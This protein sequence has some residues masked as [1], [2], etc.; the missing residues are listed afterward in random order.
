[1]GSIIPESIVEINEIENGTK[2][3]RNFAFPHLHLDLTTEDG[4]V[5]L[6]LPMN[7]WFLSI[8]FYAGPGSGAEI[9]DHISA[10]VDP[11][12]HV[13]SMLQYLG[14][15][16]GHGLTFDTI[17]E[18]DE[19]VSISPAVAANQELMDSFFRIGSFLYLG[20]TTGT[21]YTITAQDTENAKVKIATINHATRVYTHGAL[22]AHS[23]GTTIYRT[24]VA[25]DK[26]NV[27]PTYDGNVYGASKIG[28][29]KLPAGMA[30]RVH[31]YKGSGS[32]GT[33][34]ISINIEGMVG[35][36]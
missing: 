8:E 12:R 17:L 33:R 31:Y 7:F 21:E 34:D 18:G 5:D 4:Y 28:S 27:I 19:W 24:A 2:F 9:G 36:A 11:Y 20:E 29:S 13:D 3:Y 14:L 6:V 10:M 25:G 15:P 26:I 35:E 32:S 23:S 22:E 1:M 30:F 16:A